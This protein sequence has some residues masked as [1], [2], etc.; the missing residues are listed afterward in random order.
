MEAGAAEGVEKARDAGCAALGDVERD[1]QFAVRAAQQAT[2][3]RAV[4]IGDLDLRLRLEPEH[5][6]IEQRPAQEFAA[7]HDVREMIDPAEAALGAWLGGGEIVAPC[8]VA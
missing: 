3:E 6:A 8:T 2:E 4:G 7:A 5:G 1:A